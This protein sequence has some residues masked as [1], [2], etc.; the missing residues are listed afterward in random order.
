MSFIKECL[1]MLKYKNIKIQGYL[2]RMRLQR[3]LYGICFFHSWFLVGQ[4]WVISVLNHSVKYQ[5]TQ[6]NAE[7]KKQASNRHILRVLGRLHNLSLCGWPCIYLCETIQE[8]KKWCYISFKGNFQS[9]LIS[10]LQ[11][12]P[13]SL[14]PPI[15]CHPSP[16][17]NH[18]FSPHHLSS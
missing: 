12:S 11:K 7:A 15:I 17:L 10:A 14:S 9:M 13:L 2:Q 3:R 18:P 8:S 1:T 6:F 4:N 5:N 16:P